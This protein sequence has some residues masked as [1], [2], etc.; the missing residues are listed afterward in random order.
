MELL[1]EV[2][3]NG[4]ILNYQDYLKYLM[5]E[6]ET[7]LKFL[8]DSTPW[9]VIPNLTKKVNSRGEYTPFKGDTVVFPVKQ[10]EVFVKIQE[11]LYQRTGKSL[12]KPLEPEYFHITLHDLNNEID[13]EEKNKLDKMIEQS[14]LLC[15][16]ILKEL[17][18]Y[19][20]EHP[21]QSR[22]ALKSI[23]FMGP[24]I[25]IAVLFIPSAE[26]DFRILLN[27]FRL[28]QRVVKLHNPLKPHLSIGYF[29][30]KEP[31]NEEKL[32][33]LKVLNENLE[34]ELELDLWELSYQKF[35]DMNTYTTKF[36][37]KDFK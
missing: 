11:K 22:I 18:M 36:Q 23:G 30:P 4:T 1:K 33:L 21:D 3:F 9:P 14:S 27:L 29:L 25:G 15:H 13:I 6:K 10:R 5:D 17:A 19:L 32:E 12:A 24:P 7:A 26:K 34:I 2:H 35:I 28:F 31:S 37:V 16:H 8:Q 20:N